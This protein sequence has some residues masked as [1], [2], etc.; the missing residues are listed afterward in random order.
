MAQVLRVDA[1]RGHQVDGANAGDFEGLLHG[2]EQAVTSAL[3]NGELEQFHAVNGHAA[4]EHAVA[5]MARERV[6]QRGLTRTVGSHDDVDLARTHRKVEALQDLLA[7]HLD[8][9]ALDD[10]IR[11]HAVT[12]LTR[13]LA[14]TTS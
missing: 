1:C 3:G 4:V 11:R 8:A 2:Q 7:R 5:R 6:R 14:T 10:Q 9:Q 12:T 13:P